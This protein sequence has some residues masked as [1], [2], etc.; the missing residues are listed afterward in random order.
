MILEVDCGNSFIKWRI[1]QPELGLSV[2]AGVVCSCVELVAGVSAYRKLLIRARLVSVRSDRETETFCDELSRA[3]GIAISRAIPARMLGGVLN[4]YQDHTRL[5]LD[6]WLAIVAAYR[7]KRKAALVLDLGTAVTADL[8][9][10]NGVHL[11][12]YIAPGMSLLRHELQAHTQRVR[13]DQSSA[14][15]AVRK[16]LPG[17]STVE[18]VERGCLIMLRA[19]VDAQIAS[20]RGLLGDEVEVF[21]TGGDS[22][23]ITDMP[24]IHHVPDLVFRGLAVACP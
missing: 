16:M 9:A 8:V 13:Y 4:G 18:A 23:L 6:R 3:L 10:D 24:G 20:A 21:T 5:G 19:F 7:M 12:G 17:T 22:E 11:G 1:F 15:D 2:A 14:A